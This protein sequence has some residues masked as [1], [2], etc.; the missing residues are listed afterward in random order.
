MVSRSIVPRSVETAPAGC[1]AA[2]RARCSTRMSPPSHK[3]AAR[4]SALRSSRTLP[5][6]WYRSSASRA[7]RVRPAGGPSE[8]FADVLQQRFAEREDVGGALPQR[9]DR[10]VEHLQPVEQVLAE[11]AAFDGF[12]QVAVGRGDHANVCFQVRVA[13]S[14]WNSRSCSTR[15]NF[16]CAARLISVTSSRNSTPFEASSI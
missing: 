14:R 10:D 6:Q 1:P 4:S 5:G 11:V 13:P 2:S 8:R 16:A 3:M 15:R 12:A 7:S 9:R